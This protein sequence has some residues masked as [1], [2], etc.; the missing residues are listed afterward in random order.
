[1]KYEITKK[2]IGGLLKGLTITQTM[3]SDCGYKIGQIVKNPCGKS[4]PYKI[5]E[6]RKYSPTVGE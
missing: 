4:S 3:N 5:L 1:M 2:F 6:I